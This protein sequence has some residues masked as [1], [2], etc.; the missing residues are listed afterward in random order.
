MST[1]EIEGAE[2]DRTSHVTIQ[3]VDGVTAR[4]ELAELRLACP[5]ADCNRK[6]QQG[7]SVQPAVERGDTVTITHAE[8][9]GAFGLSLDWSDGHSTGIYAFSYLRDHLDRGNLGTAS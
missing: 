6:R 5:C 9:T 3:F 2:V 4:Y 1:H 8:F 7:V